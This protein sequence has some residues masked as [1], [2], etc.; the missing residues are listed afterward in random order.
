MTEDYSQAHVL[1]PFLD[2]FIEDSSPYAAARCRLVHDGSLR[3]QL[4][5]DQ[6]PLEVAWVEQSD[7]GVIEEARGVVVRAEGPSDRVRL[8]ARHVARRLARLQRGDPPHLLQ[9]RNRNPQRLIWDTRL[10]GHLCPEM[11]VRGRTRYFAYR[12][13]EVDAFEGY[14]NLT[15]S[16]RRQTVRLRLQLG[17]LG[18]A[19]PLQTW[20]PVS[21]V[22]L[23]DDR[24]EE[25]RGD[26]EH[27]VEQFVGY[28]LSRNLPPRFSLSFAHMDPPAGY[29][30]PDHGVDFL[31]PTNLDDSAFFEMLLATGGQVALVFSCDRE[32]FNLFSLV[33]GAR[34]RWTTTA[35][36]YVPPAAGLLDHVLSLN[37]T[38]RA[39][40]MGDDR[41]DAC[42]TALARRDPA[43][44]LVVL[45]DS[46]LS[47]LVGADVDGPAGRFARSSAVPL[48]RYDIRLTQSPPMGPLRE[49]WRDLASALDATG[50][51]AGEVEPGGVA[52]VGLHPGA[53]EELFATL[54]AMGLRPSGNLFPRLDL[55]AFCAA[56]RARSVVASSW[57]YLDDMGLL[58]ALPPAAR[59]PLPYGV[60]GT[61]AWLEAVARA[62][63]PG[64]EHDLPADE[65]EA[66][67][68]ELTRQRERTG[69][70]RVGIFARSR[71]VVAQLS[72]E[73]RFG[74][75]LLPLLRELGLGVDLNL[76]A[77]ADEEPDA[78]GLLTAL[79]LDAARGDSVHLYR[80]RAELPEL[81]AAGDYPVVYTE[82][83][84]DER[85]T[86]AGKTPLS[87]A[88]LHPG[89][90]GA[91]R[92]ART[93]RSLVASRFYGRYHHLHDNPLARRRRR[94]EVT[95]G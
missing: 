74:V 26:P 18:G 69:E 10:F 78:G 83:F 95:R 59:L 30:P 44:E 81:L 20:G 35:P 70:A 19:E 36:W 75:P 76:Y 11:L 90:V 6:G 61:A 33:G 82:T 2:R 88:Q 28:L 49:F 29:L 72:P 93:L 31:R 38:T 63:A 27:Q 22:I 8:A 39:T 23:E 64:A 65:F 60:E 47:K 3:V 80:D 46:C 24:D 17:D 66:A 42:L 41:L 58:E 84:R 48:V 92:T 71:D 45:V 86:A 50:D 67:A 56:R 14:L 5:D 40:L 4:E 57:T 73:K 68:E 79:D 25:Q 1:L 91:V 52:F 62:A 55:G 77:A 34:E 53:E 54:E 87:P 16:S 13:A 15:F 21:L 9:F 7:D 94:E 51:D 37:L 85:I 12:L 89:L 43:P 32:C